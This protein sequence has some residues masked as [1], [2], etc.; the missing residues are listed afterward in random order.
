MLKITILE[1]PKITTENIYVYANRLDFIVDQ[2]TIYLWPKGI[3]Q[4]GWVVGSFRMIA[5]DV[6]DTIKDLSDD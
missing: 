6:E 2:H 5:K 1:T 3:R 4:N